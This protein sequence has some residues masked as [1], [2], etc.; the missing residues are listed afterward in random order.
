GDI[1][2]GNLEAPITKGRE[3]K[4]G[5]MSFRVNPGT[6][7]ALKDAGFTI[8]SLANNHSKNFGEKGLIDT[9]SYLKNS[10]IA[11]VGAGHEKEA[12]APVYLEKKGIRFAFLAYNDHD[13]VPSSYRA[14]GKRIGT[15]FMDVKRMV[16]G[17]QEAKKNADIVV[18]SMHSG[19]E[20]VV[21][22]NKSQVSF[23]R[24]AVDAG[25][26]LVIGHHP[27]VVQSMEIY[28]GKY[29]FYSLGNFVFDQMWSQDTREG[30]VVKFNF[31]KEG[32]HS[33]DLKPVLIHNFAQP[34]FILGKQAEKI[35]KR[36]DTRVP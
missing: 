16:V 23:A 36:L 29:I 9:F 7:I 20:Y 25:A 22:P 6:E 1:V 24:A 2:F 35:I 26:D 28:K 32:V 33:F 15:A 19:T 30:L 31:T 3:V 18:V 8:V 4:V 21:K 11:Y 13:V 34:E 12:Y 5:E 27:H 14:S 10:G 17:V